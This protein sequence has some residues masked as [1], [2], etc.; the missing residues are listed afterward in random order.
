MDL[1]RHILARVERLHSHHQRTKLMASGTRYVPPDDPAFRPASFRVFDQHLRIALPTTLLDAPT[2]ML[3]LLSAGQ[4][5]LPESLRTPPQELKTLASWLYY[6]VGETKRPIP[7]RSAPVYARSFPD[8]ADA[9][10]CYEIYVAIFALKD[11]EPGLYHFCPRDFSL[12]KL[13]DGLPALLQIKKGRPDLEFLKTLPAA[14][15]VAGSY[16]RSAWRYGRRGYRGML[17][18]VGQVVQNLFT[19]GAGLGLQTVTRLRMTDSTM[20]ELIG[21]PLDE[22]FETA[23]SVHAMVAWADRA[24]EPLAIPPGARAPAL[25]AIKRIPLA[26]KLLAD[27]G[28]LEPQFMHQ[29]CVAPGVAVQQVRPPLTELDPL[30]PTHPPA[31]LP[32]IAEL[33]PGLPVRQVL[34]DRPART[35]LAR[36]PI[37]RT[38]LMSISRVTFRGGSF[39][40]VFPD[41]PHLGAIRPFWIVHE[42][43][44]M[45][46]G[47]WYYNSMA[48]QWHLLQAGEFRRQSAYIAAD[49]PPFGDAAA[50]CVLC[51]NL[52]TLMTQGGPD[53]YRLA[54]LEAGIAAQRIHLAAGALKLACLT[55]PEFYD[56]DAR[57][58]FGLARTGWEALHVVAISPRSDPNAASQDQKASALGQVGM[59][60]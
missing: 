57:A 44:G 39:F 29:D 14:I 36:Q 5:A 26:Q 58:F 38:S 2:G 27:P 41:G 16:L 51:A 19:A 11:V 28:V 3:T 32:L 56:E 25:E 53:T 8:P 20:R 59:W 47:L 42:V 43:T 22:P 13:R 7:G 1:P 54:H 35:I 55:T 4:D 31:N 23:E 30:P 21:V 46:R 17:L 12:R 60:K 9:C 6:A 40:P 52:H 18:E 45:D 34:L 49:R 48:D 33:E 15:L 10:G 37:P 50:V 24:P